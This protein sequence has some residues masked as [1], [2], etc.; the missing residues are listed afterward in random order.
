VA[1][2][3]IVPVRVI[4][5]LVALVAVTLPAGA[6]AQ[7]LKGSP[8][9]LDR[10]SRQARLHDFTYV[11]RP[12]QLDRFVDAGLLVPVTG[13]R[14][15]VL[16]GVSHDVARPEVRLFLERTGAAYRRACGERMVVTSLTRPTSQQPAN[17]SRRSVHPTGMAVDLRRPVG[18]ACRRWLENTLVTLEQRG[19]L[20]ATLEHRPPHYHVAVFPEEYAALV[21]RV[22]RPPAVPATAPL[23]AMV[24]V[25]S[26]ADA[27]SGASRP[28]RHIV[29]AGETLW[30]ISQQYGTSVALLQQFNRLGSN[31]IAAGQALVVPATS[32]A[33]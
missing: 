26:V 19:V 32:G 3:K 29:Q 7:S 10:Q 12:M 13:N 5:W 6:L 9:S 14:N 33:R 11:A 21:G 28:T 17:A 25:S 22:R 31:A 20:E 23:R 27:S 15:Y 1:R 2:S 16:E 8:S 4:V 30:R 24:P 18:P